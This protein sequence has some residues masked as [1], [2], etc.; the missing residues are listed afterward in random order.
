MDTTTLIGYLATS[1]TTFAFLP[2]VLR[3]Y[4]TKRADDLSLGMLAVYIAGILLWI[5]MGARQ[6]FVHGNAQGWPVL[7]GNLIALALVGLNTTLALRYRA[8]P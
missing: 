8:R 3:T 6:V 2:Q 7:I 5:T 1:C 4:R